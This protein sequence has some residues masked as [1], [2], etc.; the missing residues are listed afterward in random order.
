MQSFSVSKNK[1]KNVISYLFY[2][3]KK[4]NIELIND[5][6]HLL[7]FFFKSKKTGF[8]HPLIPSITPGI[9]YNVTPIISFRIF[10]QS[11]FRLDGKF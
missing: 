5:F 3:Y 1:K 11:I 8:S 7:Y 10:L 2:F 9:Y 6:T 4:K